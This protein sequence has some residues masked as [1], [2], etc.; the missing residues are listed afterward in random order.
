MNKQPGIKAAQQEVF[1]FPA[2]GFYILWNKIKKIG[3]TFKD[4]LTHICNG[5]GLYP[6]R[7][8]Y[9][10]VKLAACWKMKSVVYWY[11]M[12][13]SSLEMQK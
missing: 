12:K 8:F 13:W 7:A 11:V 3:Y 6:S 2:S 5:I 9:R 10:P 1:F 4:S